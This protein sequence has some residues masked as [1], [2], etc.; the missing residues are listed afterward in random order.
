MKFT[1]SEMFWVRLLFKYIGVLT[2]VLCLS[3]LGFLKSYSKRE[4]IKQLKTLDSA[5]SRA[6]DMLRLGSQSSGEIIR[7]CFG[8]ETNTAAN[9]IFTDKTAGEINALLDKF[10]CEF[11]SG[12]RQLEH[13]RISRVKSELAVLISAKEAEYEQFG[14]IWR[15]AGVCAGLCLGIMLV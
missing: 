7:E 10:F 6:D 2:V 8:K 15:T 3:V 9:V 12:D 14:K 13:S 11:G 1:V 4:Q 5:L